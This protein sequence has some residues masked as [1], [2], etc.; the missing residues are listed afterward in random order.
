MVEMARSMLSHK[1]FPN[2]FWAEAITTSIHFLTLLEILNFARA[3]R[4][5][6]VRKS[7]RKLLTIT[8]SNDITRIYRGNILIIYLARR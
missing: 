2:E 3:H 5:D 6:I 8:N 7:P 4:D 1:K